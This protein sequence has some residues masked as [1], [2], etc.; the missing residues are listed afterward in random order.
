M[1]DFDSSTPRSDQRV[2]KLNDQQVQKALITKH[3][4]HIITKK[5]VLKTM[6]RMSICR[7]SVG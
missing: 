2:K 3:I 4:I 5:R 6:R 1:N 7:T